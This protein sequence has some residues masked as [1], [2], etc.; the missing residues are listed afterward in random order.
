V[1]FDGNFSV[2][3]P[4]PVAW[5][6]L[7]DARTFA[8]CV[9]YIQNFE[10]GDEDKFKVSV[11]SP[12]TAISGSL[13][14][15]FSY[16]EQDPPRHAKIKGIGRGLKSTFDFTGTLDLEEEPNETTLIMWVIEVDA[17][18]LVARLG[19]RVL[20]SVVETAAQK[21]MANVQGKLESYAIQG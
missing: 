16:I 11:K 18:G 6:L 12:F 21:V 8:E 3:V 20:S 13:A 1:L 14:F 4:R 15:E 9:P 17:A 5:N 2:K 19:Q 7:S 10:V